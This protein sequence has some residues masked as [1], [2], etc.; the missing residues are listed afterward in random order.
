MDTIIFTEEGRECLRKARALVTAAVRAENNFAKRMT[1][2]S[3]F[4]MSEEEFTAKETERAS[5]L[6]LFTGEITTLI[7]ALTGDH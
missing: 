1:V 6:A 4:A 5:G 2:F 7:D 3:L